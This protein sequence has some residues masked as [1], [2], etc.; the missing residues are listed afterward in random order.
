MNILQIPLFYIAFQRDK[1]I[2]EHYASHGFQNVNH[3]TAIAGKKLDIHKLIKTNVIS[4]RSF[5]DLMSGRSEHSG[6]PSL[7]AI[8]C[9]LSHYYLW[10]LCIDSGLKY[11][12]IAE[13]D[14]RITDLDERKLEHINEIISKPN[15][16]FISQ[17]IKKQD[18]RTHFFGTHFCIISQEACKILMKNFLP[19]DVQVDWYIANQATIG[20]INLE[21]FR[22]SQQRRHL[23]SIQTYSN[24]K[25]YLPKSP[26]F[27]ICIVIAIGIIIILAVYFKSKWSTCVKTCKT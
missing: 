25:V 22:V 9:S 10:K 1:N 5:D 7:G 26:Y 16:I 24:I 19:I 4:I 3:F 14:N 17:N 13:E 12:I 27:H 2:E 21:G 18:H 23:S 15:G 8:G 11:I 6:M 20:N